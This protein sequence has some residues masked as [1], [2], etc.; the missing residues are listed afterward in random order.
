MLTVIVW[1]SAKQVGLFL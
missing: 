1:S